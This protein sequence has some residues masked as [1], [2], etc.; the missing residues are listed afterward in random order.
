MISR[1]HPATYT[2]AEGSEVSGISRDLLWSVCRRLGLSGEA[3]PYEL[4]MELR[5]HVDTIANHIIQ[6][7]SASSYFLQGRQHGRAGA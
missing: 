1:L 5:W 2:L 4:A 6:R 3:V 7:D